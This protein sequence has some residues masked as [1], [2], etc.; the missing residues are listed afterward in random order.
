MHVISKRPLRDFWERHPDSKEELNRWYRAA[1]KSKWRHLIDVRQN[2]NHADA[3][4]KCIV[5]NIKGNRYRLIVK[6]RFDRQTAFVKAVLTHSE[7][8]KGNWKDECNC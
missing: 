1:S 5:F 8:D 2:F 6:F 3:V 7:Y 4:G